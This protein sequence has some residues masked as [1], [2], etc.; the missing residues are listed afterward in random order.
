M[1]RSYALS[2]Q[3][4]VRSQPLYLPCLNVP[5]TTRQNVFSSIELF[6]LGILPQQWN[7]SY[8]RL[9]S[10]FSSAVCSQN[11]SP[12]PWSISLL[13]SGGIPV[14]TS[15]HKS[16]KVL[17]LFLCS[18]HPPYFMFAP[19]NTPVLHW[20]HS[21]SRNNKLLT[22]LP[23]TMMNL[24]CD[25]WHGK[26]YLFSH[27]LCL[28]F[29]LALKVWL[30][31]HGPLLPNSGNAWMHT[32]PQFTWKLNLQCS[33]VVVSKGWASGE[34]TKHGGSDLMSRINECIREFSECFQVNICCSSAMWDNRKMMQP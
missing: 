21:G 26:Y 27:G 4:H 31:C 15:A 8:T 5:K 14:P 2:L 25:L 22:H 33:G 3:C 32:P 13:S 30:K 16:C 19:V 34:V 20:E 9:Y 12:Y 18:L 28:W 17:S 10:V 6:P 29:R 23:H 7:M 24:S 11:L 1:W